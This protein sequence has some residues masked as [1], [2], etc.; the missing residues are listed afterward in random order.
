M[1]TLFEYISSAIN[2][3][4]GQ[5]GTDDGTISRNKWADYAANGSK[6]DLF[7]P[8]DQA[9]LNSWSDWILN[10]LKVPITHVLNDY[11]RLQIGQVG[12][13]VRA[14]LNKMLSEKYASQSY[15]DSSMSA[16]NNVWTEDGIRFLERML[17]ST[18][19]GFSSTNTNHPFVA[20][21]LVTYFFLFGKL[22]ESQYIAINGEGGIGGS[23]I[24]SNQGVR[25]VLRYS[26]SNDKILTERAARVVAMWEKYKGG[27]SIG[28]GSS[29]KLENLGWDIA[30]FR[31]EATQE[32]NII[33][34][35]K[36]KLSSGETYLV[37]ADPQALVN[38]AKL[39]GN[40][41]LPYIDWVTPVGSKSLPKVPE[42]SIEK[43][44][45]SWIKT[46]NWPEL[47]MNVNI[48]ET[49]A[50]AGSREPSVIEKAVVDGSKT[51]NMMRKVRI[52][53]I[54]IDSQLNGSHAWH[55]T[56]DETNG[57]TYK[58]LQKKAKKIAF[59]K[60]QGLGP[61]GPGRGFVPQ[62]DGMPTDSDPTIL[63]NSYLSIIEDLGK[64]WGMPLFA[65]N[66]GITTDAGSWFTVLAKIGDPKGKDN[67]LNIADNAWYRLKHVL[68]ECGTGNHADQKAYGLGNAALKSDEDLLKE[69]IGSAGYVMAFQFLYYSAMSEVI[70]LAQL[71][72]ELKGVELTDD[73][74]NEILD[75]ALKADSTA[76]SDGAGASALEEEKDVPADIDERQVFLRQ[77][78]L[79]MN[80]D[81]MKRAC[82]AEFRKAVD[83]NTYNDRIWTVDVDN[84]HKRTDIINFLTAAPY[85]TI[86][87]FLELTPELQ[88]CLV[89]KI[90]FFKVFNEKNNKDNIKEVEFSFPFRYD[91][92]DSNYRLKNNGIVFRGGGSG[93]KSFSFSFEG[94]SP[95][96][97]RNDITA[98]LSLF[99]Q[100]FADLLKYRSG[101]DLFSDKGKSDKFRYI[102]MLLLPGNKVNPS[103]DSENA[104]SLYEHYAAFNAT[105]HRIRADVGWVIRDDK[106]FRNLVKN[107]GLAE[108]VKTKTKKG[109]KEDILNLINQALENINKSYYLNMVDHNIDFLDDGSVEL[110]VNYRAWLESATK[111][112]NLD[113]MLSPE[114]AKDRLAMTK[115]YN[116]VMEDKICEKGDDLQELIG[117]FNAIE[118]EYM[119]R[120]HQSIIERLV[121][122]EKLHYCYIDERDIQIF[123]DKG[124]F[125]NTPALSFGGGRTTVNTL[126]KNSAITVKDVVEDD[127]KPLNEQTTKKQFLDSSLTDLNETLL[128]PMSTQKF[129]TFFFFGD[130]M[131]TVMDCMKDPGSGPPYTLYPQFKKTKII[132]SSFDYV[133]HLFNDKNVN[134]SEIPIS[135]EYFFEWM[136]QNVIKPKRKTYPLT[137]FMRDLCNKLIA[138]LMLEQCI[139]R[140]PVKTLSFK[141]VN[142]L[143]VVDE[144]DEPDPF[145]AMNKLAG[146]GHIN[147]GDAHANQR[148]LPLRGNIGNR[149]LNHAYNYIAIYP[150]SDNQKYS[151]TG[152][153]F[154][155]GKRGIY[156]FSIGSNKG[157]VKTIKFSKTDIQYIREAR[158]FNHGHDGLMQLSA[159]YK[160]TLEM[161]GNTIFYPGMLIFIDPRELGGSDF[162]PTKGQS[163]AKGQSV[164]NALGIGG[165]HLITRVTSNLESGNFTTTVE[166]QFVY[167]G[168][169]TQSSIHGNKTKEVI[170][171][172][173]E[174]SNQVGQGVLNSCNKITQIYE[175]VLESGNLGTTSSGLKSI[176]GASD[177]D[178]DKAIAKN[179]VN[180]SVIPPK[181][182]P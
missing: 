91:D 154:E 33:V 129:V 106:L 180:N 89:P 4:Y 159:V 176:A 22:S 57:S 172:N 175:Q 99:F 160:V 2:D 13:V 143:G 164:A 30:R 171:V 36:I 67:P 155:D 77:C 179:A 41:A 51:D 84:T 182:S 181:G 178:K 8:E 47:K 9:A 151:G 75:K 61:Q 69:A 87:A 65:G 103:K 162:D 28:E 43:G 31:K 96:T 76:M 169:G 82:Q 116:K 49:V 145:L 134:L 78:A 156:H 144:A 19:V 130:L 37:N 174:D 147:L 158:F 123:K 58:K 10:H 45:T 48:H 72:Y 3:P 150:V 161:F 74:I 95:A 142:L 62:P 85:K 152:N 166:A 146:S 53:L 73:K 66:E 18:K 5:D 102:D 170:T 111:Q 32:A 56:L 46:H 39:Q 20:G 139:N 104:D 140:S 27:D 168:D 105:D 52:E 59:V 149:S 94:T 34:K 97:A 54:D 29:R 108:I 83:P 141:T 118:V 126:N 26:P 68:Q 128:S 113:A 50:V 21:D 167:S 107:R 12:T 125:T 120:A 16:G 148:G 124:F 157:I 163:H 24:Y 165:Y 23:Y 131:H 38:G 93:I 79:L 133:D 101:D 71:I 80:M 153:F 70:E 60:L 35:G 55:F 11:T 109:T 90:R 14:F 64:W 44:F 17:E 98:E 15:F 136:N 42:H 63:G 112:N 177:A 86:G 115:D 6:Y 135:T 127:S 7:G 88:A 132:L 40:T 117:T 122:N 119:K 100:D 92:N 1:S 81:V 137:Y 110:K 138:N 121:R 173:I 114:L 25:F